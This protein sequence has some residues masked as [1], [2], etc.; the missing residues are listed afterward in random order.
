M[1][2]NKMTKAVIL[3]GGKG[4]RFHPFTFTIPKPLM[5]IA[6][7]PILLHLINQFKKFNITNFMISTGFQAELIK[8]Y[9]GSGE[10]FNVKA[11]YFHEE[12]PLGTAGPLALM[13]DH[14]EKD[15]Y[16]FLINGDIYTEMDFD[17]MLSF[18]EKGQYDIVVGCIEK[19]E[20]SSFGVIEIS[21]NEIQEIVE[22]PERRFNISSGIYVINSRALNRVPHDTFYTMPDL[23]NSYLAENKKVG[24]FNIDKF[25]LGIEDVESMDV[26]IK[27]VQQFNSSSDKG[28]PNLLSQSSPL[29]YPS[30]L[31]PTKNVSLIEEGFQ[32]KDTL[33]LIVA[34]NEARSIGAV[35]R[36]VKSSLPRA[37]VL[38][39]DG[40]S[41]DNTVLVSREYGA[42]VIQV[43]KS[44]GIGGAVEAGI[45]YASRN[46]YQYLAR[47]DADGQHRPAEIDG[48][49]SV[50]RRN[51][52]DFVI[53]S[54][55]L[56]DSEYKPN[57]LRNSSIVL[58]SSLI[59]WLY[60]LKVSD[61]TSGCQLYNRKLIDYFA[62]DSRFE[63]SEVRAIWTAHKAGFR[64]VEKF[65]NM[66]PR[67][68]G[69][70]SFSTVNASLYMFKNLVDILFSGSISI[71]KRRA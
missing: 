55:F 24:A 58:I 28:S 12:Q 11:S 68:E 9:I 15:E 52:A 1:I 50:L 14:F 34:L 71:G 66:A 13:K 35:I 44:F 8:A 38:V 53:G 69:K 17:Q 56:G 29:N 7:D 39:V 31:G 43:A 25:W 57:L 49:L 3:A 41:T 45:L 18:A 37:D 16:F 62:K 36:E 51:E 32:A 67:S 10:R 22:K 23:I 5:P 27:R 60:N 48:L 54:R 40:Y 19:R 33:V 30:K 20:K 61:C 46:G 63:Y 4:T 6:Q 64:I 21:N 70:S 65:I 59:R 2:K 42:S 47:I 26:V